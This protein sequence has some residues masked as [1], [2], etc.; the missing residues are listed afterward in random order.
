MGCAPDSLHRAWSRERRPSHRSIL[1][2][3]TLHLSGGACGM[4]PLSFRAK[5]GF[6]VFA[7][8][9]NFMRTGIKGFRCKQ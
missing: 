8:H 5:F 9:S 3:L 7:A 4:A 2:V 1:L 6:K